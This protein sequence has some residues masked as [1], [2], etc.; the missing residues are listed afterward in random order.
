MFKKPIVS[1]LWSDILSKDRRCEHPLAVKACH[2]WKITV[3]SG[4]LLTADSCAIIYVNK[5]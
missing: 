1:V 2:E 5:G 4:E 3:L